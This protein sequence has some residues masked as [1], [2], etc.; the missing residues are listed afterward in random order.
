MPLERRKY[1]TRGKDFAS[2]RGLGMA[3]VVAEEGAFGAAAAAA[4]GGGEGGTIGP[5]AVKP[6]RCGTLDAAPAKR[7]GLERAAAQEARVPR[8]RRI[9][10][11]ATAPNI[12][13]ITAPVVYYLCMYLL[14]KVISSDKK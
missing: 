4:V 2:A 6:R 10:A 11:L 1:R 9:A 7:E 12:V 13:V 5:P 8:G 14:S 3:F